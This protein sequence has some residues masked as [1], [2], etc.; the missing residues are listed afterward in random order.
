[1]SPRVTRAQARRTSPRKAAAAGSASASRGASLL[2]VQLP[3][4]DEDDDGDYQPSGSEVDRTSSPS[5]SSRLD[6]RFAERALYVCS[7]HL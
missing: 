5:T 4:D 1:M 3:D 2:E 6:S 7:R